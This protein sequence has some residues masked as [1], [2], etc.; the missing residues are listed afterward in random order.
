MTA[1]PALQ[2]NNFKRFMAK[3]QLGACIALLLHKNI[4]CVTVENMLNT[5][6][7]HLA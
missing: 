7:E 1:G 3:Y 6:F 5:C 4:V 2:T